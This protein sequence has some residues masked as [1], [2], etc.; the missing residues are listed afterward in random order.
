MSSEFKC[1]QCGSSFFGSRLEG[2]PKRKGYSADARF[3][4]AKIVERWCKGNH[5]LHGGLWAYDGCSFRW[6]PEDDV[7]YGLGS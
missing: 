6:K 4:G 7:M 2:A 5:R 3:E 1:P